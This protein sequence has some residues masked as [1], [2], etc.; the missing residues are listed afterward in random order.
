M[1]ETRDLIAQ[2]HMQATAG[3]DPRGIG[4]RAVEEAYKVLQG[5]QPEPV[6]KLPTTLITRENVKHSSGEGWE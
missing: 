2:G 3:Q 6:V 5:Q 4:R 1:T